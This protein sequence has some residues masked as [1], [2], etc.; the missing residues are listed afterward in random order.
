MPSPGT[1]TVQL[2]PGQHLA[3]ISSRSA[4]G[5]GG[6]GTVYKARDTRLN[7][8]VALKMLY[9]PGQRRCAGALPSG[10]PG[11]RP[12]EPHQPL[13]RHRLRRPRRHRLHRHGLH[14][15]AE[16]RRVA[17]DPFAGAAQRRPAG[18]QAGAG[19][20]RGARGRRHSPRPE[21]R[22]RGHQQERRAGHPRLRPGPAG[23]RPAFAADAV[24]RH[25]GHALV[26]G[27]RASDGR[28]RKSARRRTSIRSA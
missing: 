2:Q 3:T 22:Q 1:S 18:P 17:P 28:R 10:S 9:H 23:G 25:D 27:P 5:Q 4:L 21:A 15:R 16:P 20:A 14:R 26:H 6:M 11:G 12:A 24:G 19:H 8:N 7:R 13:S